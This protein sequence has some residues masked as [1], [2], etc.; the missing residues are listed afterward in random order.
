MNPLALEFV[1]Y[2][3][4][5]NPGACDFATIY[6]AMTRTACTRSFRNLSYRELAQ[7]GISFSLLSTNELEYLIIE[8]QKALLFD[9]A[10]KL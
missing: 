10:T 7:I 9:E 6:D 8:A 5:H 2:T 4:R 1:K 3:L